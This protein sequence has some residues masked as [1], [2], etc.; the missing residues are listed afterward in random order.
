MIVQRYILLKRVKI[1]M[2]LSK[3]VKKD[4]T[5]FLLIRISSM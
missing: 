4:E 1:D 3:G 5:L 2:F